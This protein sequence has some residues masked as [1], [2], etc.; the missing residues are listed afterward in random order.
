MFNR[1][2]PVKLQKWMGS[3]FMIGVLIILIQCKSGAQVPLLTYN[4]LKVFASYCGATAFFFKGIE[5][6]FEIWNE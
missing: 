6:D 2:F 1:L 4:E 3:V 5:L